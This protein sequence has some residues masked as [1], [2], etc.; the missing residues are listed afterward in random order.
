MSAA[1]N[2]PP[3]PELRA[4][5]N[6]GN[7]VLATRDGNGAPQGIS[8][9]LAQA[10]GREFGRDVSLLPFERAVDVAESA[11]S[12]LWD[13]CF[14][15]VDPER[16]KT[17]SF[18]DPYVRIA[19]CYLVTGAAGAVSSEDVVARQLRIGVVEGSAYT[20]HLSRQAGATHLVLMPDIHA[21]LAAFDAGEVD[22]IA[23]IEQAMRA[24]ERLRPGSLVLMPPFMEIRQAM[25]VPAGRS[26]LFAEVRA[27]LARIADT[28]GLR[29][30]LESHGVAGN[31]A[32][33]PPPTQV[34][35]GIPETRD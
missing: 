2:P 22:G 4:A 8:V 32:L 21:A 11:G 16:G 28:G 13:I 5:I 6:L 24:E 1:S 7:R 12:D 9:G 26:D 34:A 31:C 14:L 17:I 27:G 33:L 20:L 3:A 10:L 19:G 30:I 23:G 18:T 29:A 25:G 15:A 35:P